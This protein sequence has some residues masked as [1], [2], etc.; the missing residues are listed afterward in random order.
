MLRLWYDNGKAKEL[1]RRV[2]SAREFET[3]EWLAK[4]WDNG[5]IA[6]QMGVDKSTV[7]TYRERI[8]HK[9][10]LKTRTDVTLLML[11]RGVL[12]MSWHERNSNAGEANS[13]QDNTSEPQQSPCND[14]ESPEPSSG[15]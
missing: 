4:G 1:Y 14:G 3:L 15:W 12:R 5:R 6:K 2:L 8:I 13:V 9:L 10:G 11:Y 7:S